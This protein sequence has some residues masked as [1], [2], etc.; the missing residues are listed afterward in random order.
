MNSK[1]LRRVEVFSQMQSEG[2]EYESKG[3]YFRPKA[4]KFERVRKPFEGNELRLKQECERKEKQ[5]LER[6]I[7]LEIV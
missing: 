4:Q 5:G 6:Y 7:T 3:A 1:E 2:G